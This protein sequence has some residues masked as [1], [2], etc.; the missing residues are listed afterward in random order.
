MILWTR[1]IINTMVKQKRYNA[2]LKQNGSLIAEIDSGSAEQTELE[3]QFYKQ[4]YAKEG[5][6]TVIRNW[7]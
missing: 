2:K 5:K 6:I 3:V 4:L 7:K 1:L